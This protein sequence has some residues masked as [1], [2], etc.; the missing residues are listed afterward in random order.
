MFEVQPSQL[1]RYTGGGRYCSRTCKHRAQ[2]GVELV[3][4]TRYVSRAGYITVKVGIR[5][6]Q[7]EHRIVMEAHLGRE[8]TAD[9]H[10]HHVNGDKQDNRVDNLQVLSNAE[11]QRLHVVLGDSGICHVGAER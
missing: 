2:C 11:H 5:K 3:T 7:L 4:G 9:E 8:L 6:Y 10:V 1:K